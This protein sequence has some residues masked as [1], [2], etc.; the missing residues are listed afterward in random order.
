MM[1][2]A[3]AVAA[4]I[5]TASALAARRPPPPDL[6]K[7]YKDTVAAGNEPGSAAATVSL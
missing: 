2:L 7:I 1:R 6:T 4:C 3:L 5:Q